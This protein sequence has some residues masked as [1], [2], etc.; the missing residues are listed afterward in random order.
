MGPNLI[1][2][3]E[4]AWPLFSATERFINKTANATAKV[5]DL[6]SQK[7]GDRIDATLQLAMDDFRKTFTLLHQSNVARTYP[8]L[9]NTPDTSPILPPGLS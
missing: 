7:Y 2:H 5:N 1:S 8:T 3:S 6:P 9:D 4:P